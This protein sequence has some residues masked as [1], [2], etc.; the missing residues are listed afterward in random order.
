MRLLLERLATPHGA[1]R[2]I[3]LGG[4]CIVR[5]STATR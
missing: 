3:V 1:R 4:T 5:G 2:K